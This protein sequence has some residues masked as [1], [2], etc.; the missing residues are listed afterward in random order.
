MSY[1][2]KNKEVEE[3]H[4]LK[5]L[6]IDYD[7]LLKMNK[8]KLSSGDKELF[9]ELNKVLRKVVKKRIKEDTVENS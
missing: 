9:N 7:Y 2:F 6:L 4:T 1:T 8:N 5:H 3:T